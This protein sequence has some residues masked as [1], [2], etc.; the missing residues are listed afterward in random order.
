M[1][2]LPLLRKEGAVNQHTH[3]LPIAE[4]FCM[5]I[6]LCPVCHRPLNH[7]LSS[8]DTILEESKRTMVLPTYD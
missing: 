7:A 2:V 5:N 1:L 3:L 8:L 4:V 6:P